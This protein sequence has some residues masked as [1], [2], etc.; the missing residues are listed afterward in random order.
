MRAASKSRIGKRVRILSGM[1]EFVGR[2][3]TIV[4][5][6]ADYYRVQLDEPVEV[7]GVGLVEDDLWQG[8]LLKTLRKSDDPIYQ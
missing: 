4:D 5:T 8:H 6:E 2:I 3:G 1:P 7:A